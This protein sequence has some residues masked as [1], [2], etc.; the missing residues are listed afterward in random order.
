MELLCP[1]CKADQRPRFAGLSDELIEG[2]DWHCPACREYLMMNGGRIFVLRPPPPP[3]QGKSPSAGHARIELMIQMAVAMV[4]AAIAWPALVRWWRGEP[5]PP[6]GWAWIA[7]GAVV[8]L[9]GAGW[10]ARTLWVGWRDSR[11]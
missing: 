6:G 9:F 7:A 3:P 5:I 8:F 10:L 11:D 4:G 2:R 1:K